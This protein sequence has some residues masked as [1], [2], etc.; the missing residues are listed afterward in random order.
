MLKTYDFIMHSQTWRSTIATPSIAA[1]KSIIPRVRSGYY[2]VERRYCWSTDVEYKKELFGFS[3]KD[4][5]QSEQKADK[6]TQT[7]IDAV[8]NLK[9]AIC[10]LFCQLDI[11]SSMFV[12]PRTFQKTALIVFARI[13]CIVS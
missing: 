8:N 7:H 13:T 12:P 3:R 10:E 5:H 1:Y 4:A 2:C 6:Q 11:Y 9:I